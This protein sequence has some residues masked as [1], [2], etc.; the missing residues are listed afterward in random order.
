MNATV[1]MQT[2][3]WMTVLFA[4]TLSGCAGDDEPTPPGAVEASP[5]A[6]AVGEATEAAE[7]QTPATDPTV[8]STPAAEP[9][10]EPADVTVDLEVLDIQLQE[11][12]SGLALPLKVVSAYDGSNRIFI[13]EKGGTIRTLLDGEVNPEPFLD[14]SERVGSDGSEQGLLGLAFHPEFPESNV[15]FVNY[16]DTDGN[17]TISRFTVDGETANPDSEE[18]LLAV[19]QPASNHNGGHLL[20]GPDGYLYIGL[21]DGGGAGDQF[22]NAQNGATL[23]GAMLRIDVDGGDPYG[24]PEDNPFV[25]DDSYRPEIWAIGL[26]NPWRYDFDRETGDLYIADVGQNQIEEINVQPGDSQGGENYGWPIMEGTSCFD[27]DECDQTGLVLP[28]AEYTHDDGCSVTGG[29]VYRG[30]T[31]PQ[32]TG[33]YFFSDF[34]SGN[35]WGLTQAHGEW[36]TRLLLETGYSVSSFGEDEA[37]ELYLVDLASGILY[38]IVANS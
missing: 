26:R 20:F 16:T 31:Y 27:A 10:E 4:F 25:G 18:V 38:A 5:T 2:I 13:V 35:L 3:F 29:N 6:E 37:G 7:S 8:G 23:L 24:I 1:R 22:G 34:C 17:T 12:A 9:T 11:V 30:E 15:F 14:I 21:G 19:E 36:Q 33:V 32:M 28:V